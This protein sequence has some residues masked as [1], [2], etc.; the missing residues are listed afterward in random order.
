MICMSLFW[1]LFW[2]ALERLVTLSYLHAHL[3]IA[4]SIHYWHYFYDF[5]PCLGLSVN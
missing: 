1:F 3:K 2:R 4:F 5:S